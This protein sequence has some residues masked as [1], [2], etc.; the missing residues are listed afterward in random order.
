MK[1]YLK[2]NLPA[3][4]RRR[5]ILTLLLVSALV[6]GLFPVWTQ[7]GRAAEEGMEQGED[8]TSLTGEP[9]TEWKTGETSWDQSEDQSTQMEDEDAPNSPA[10]EQSATIEGV[11]ITVT[12]PEGVFPDGAA[13]SVEAAE[14]KD[15]KA[16]DKAVDMIRD[17]NTNVAYSF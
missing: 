4:K 3:K 17:K 1:D 5:R 14:R 9:P 13:L 12:A 15:Q 2:T 16:V 11:T 8:G 6:F 7:P 10:F